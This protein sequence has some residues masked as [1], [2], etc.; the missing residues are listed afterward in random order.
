M[1]KK[2]KRKSTKKGS[3]LNSNLQPLIFSDH[4]GITLVALIITIIIM[5]LLVGV[6][7]TIAINGGLFDSTN[8]AA[9][10]TEKAKK[11]EQELSTERIKIDDIWYDSFEDYVNGKKSEIQGVEDLD[12]TNTTFTYNPKGWTNGEVKVAINT[13][14]LTTGYTLQYST[15]GISWSEYIAGTEIPMSRNG[16]VFAKLVDSEG[17]EGESASANIA[18]IDTKGPTITTLLNAPSTTTSSINLSIGATDTVSGFSKIEWYYKRSTAST[19]TLVT[20]EA[21]TQM[22]GSTAGIK[23]EV[24]KETTLSGLNPD[25]TYNIYA[26]VYDVAGNSTR[27]PE[28]GTQDVSTARPIPEGEGNIDFSYSNENWTNQSVDVTITQTGGIGVYTLQYST[29]GETWTDYNSPVPMSTN[30]KI[31]ARLRDPLGNGGVAKVEEV[32]IDTEGPEIN[33]HLNSTKAEGTTITLSITATDSVS[34]I[35]KIEWYYKLST[36]SEYNTPLTDT[37]TTMNGSTAGTKARETKTKTLSG[38]T[39]GETYNI[40]A[41]VYDVA[42]NPT[43]SPEDE[44]VSVTMPT[45][46][47]KTCRATLTLK[48][49]N[50]NRVEECTCSYCTNPS[51]WRYVGKH[52]V[53]VNNYE[54]TDCG[55]QVTTYKIETVTVNC[56]CSGSRSELGIPSDDPKYNHKLP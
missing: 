26:I 46:S 54:C 53:I 20:P 22:N 39:A 16:T 13:T 37:Y 6:S 42:G 12:E 8:K 34:G 14:A 32:K 50:N 43:R 18:N 31:Y 1:I 24:I 30:G 44:F 56:K 15:D 2:S 19:Y 3:N 52:G 36:A 48:F 10:K 49:T 33:T 41:I 51:N 25:T 35:S 5:L 17:N 38:L 28:S 40:Y 7:I 23:T 27:F 4:R 47:P 11:T 55:L 21:D 9:K 45:V 29:D